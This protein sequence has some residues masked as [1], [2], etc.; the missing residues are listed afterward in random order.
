MTRLLWFVGLIVVTATA[1]AQSSSILVKLP[2]GVLHVKPWSRNVVRVT[3]SKNQAIP[4]D[5]IPAVIAAPQQFESRKTAAGNDVTLATGQLNVRVDRRTGIVHFLDSA[6]HALC[7]EAACGTLQPVTLPG[8]VPESSFRSEQKFRL[9]PDESYYGLGQH[10]DGLLDYRGTSVLLSQKNM[11][12]AVPFLVSSKGYGIL[13]NN[14]AKT[15]VDSGGVLAPSS[16]I[17]ADGQ[18]GAL[19]GEY[20]VG[21]NFEKSVLRRRDS[22]IDFNWTQHP[23]AGLPH[24]NYTVRWTGSVVASVAG[25]YTFRASADDGVR[26]W[27]D[28]K[29]VFDD[30]SIHAERPSAGQ[31]T[32]A[33]HSKHSV[34][35]EFF[36]GGRD[37][38]IQFGWRTPGGSEVTWRSEAADSIDYFFVYGPSTDRVIAGYRYLT[39]QAPMPAKWALGYWQS[40]ERYKTQQELLDIADEYRAKKLP[41]DNLVQDWFY[42]DPHPWG[43]HL[44]DEKR[45]PDPAAAFLGLHDRHFHVMISVWGKFNPGSAQYPNANYEE[46]SNRG[47]LYPPAVSSPDRYYDAFSEDAR[48]V[49][50]RQIRRQLFSQGIDAWWLDASEPEADLN[51]LAQTPTGAG[52]GAHVLSAWPL[53]HTTGV[54]QGQRSVTDQKR[55]FILTRSAYAGQQRNGAATWSGDIGASWDTLARQIPAG[56]NFCLSGI[57][58]WTTDIGAFYV[59][60]RGGADNPEYREL[61]TRWFEYGAFCPIFRSHGTSTPREMWRFGPEVQAILAKYDNLRYRLMPYIYSQ[62]WNVTSS[63]GT[64]MRSLLFDFPSDTTARDCKDEFM[65]GPS[66]LICPVLQKGAT[67]RRVYLPAG[68]LWTDFW[69]G[70]THQGGSWIAADA[71][72]SKE[73]IFVRGGSILPMGPFLQYATE[74]PANPMELRLF[75]GGNGR[76]E[77]YEDEGDGYGYEKG[78]YATIPVSWSSRT[79]VIRFGAR[80]G[81]F[82]GMLKSRVFLIVTNG[83][84]VEGGQTVRAVKYD[85]RAAAFRVGA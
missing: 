53:M 62:A 25:K 75:G 20:F 70:A 36:Q 55:V 38:V 65:F 60:Y 79:G 4:Q 78:L 51:V 63:S 41:I 40:K 16:L 47:Y 11:E 28:G 12:V 59:P 1:E 9:A 13:W 72:L 54:Y 3:F 23:P 76:T 52:L 49:Y 35:L 74:K 69:T 10:Q 21:R 45:Y 8:P 39:G 29:P 64:I 30:W 17:D 56:L 15:V 61:Y 58:Y 22:Q 42:W 57:P 33:A 68:A 43:S 37:S 73:P 85:G 34:R 48:S 77:I 81:S 7:E 66:L 18:P 84:G 50:W 5:R 24:D 71:P 83:K 67:S 19:T 32:F 80:Q 31:V 14:P 44:F 26:L 46:L 82:P 6:G 27:I 2:T